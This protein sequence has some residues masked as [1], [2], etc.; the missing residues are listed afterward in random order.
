MQRARRL[1]FVALGGLGV[2]LVATVVAWVIDTRAHQG[3][4]LRNTKLAGRS[5]GGL[6]QRQLAAAVDAITAKFT[7]SQVDVKAP[8]GGF[9]VVSPELGLSIDTAATVKAAMTSGRTGSL[10]RRYAGWVHALSRHRS[11]PL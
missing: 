3:E 1:L 6:D 8:G 7:T 2:V 9:R 5:I 11:S 10:P 4:V